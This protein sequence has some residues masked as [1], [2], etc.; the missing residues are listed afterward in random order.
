MDCT[1]VIGTVLPSLAF[2]NQKFSLLPLVQYDY[3]Q[4]GNS[5]LGQLVSPNYIIQG[6]PTYYETYHPGRT[7]IFKV[8]SR[9]ILYE[10]FTASHYSLNVE[11]LHI[12]L[13][14]FNENFT[15]TDFS[16]TFHQ[17]A[18]N[19]NGLTDLR[20]IL[21]V[22]SQTAVDRQE[23]KTMK[24]AMQMLTTSE[25]DDANINQV[26]TSLQNFAHRT[27]L[28]ALSEIS[29]PFVTIIFMALQILAFIWAV[30]TTVKCLKK[31]AIPFLCNARKRAKNSKLWT[32]MRSPTPAKNLPDSKDDDIETTIKMDTLNPSDRSRQLI[33]RFSSSHSI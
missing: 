11:P 3:K 5:R 7:L 27:L 6:E 33:R 25:K 26:T 24:T 10:N 20:S 13:S 14:T 22:L 2:D 29:S 18:E 19:Q 31:N 28:L 16:S 17:F 23:M 8:N 4:N 12:P 15:A 21:S 1:T 32:I 30:V 9:Y